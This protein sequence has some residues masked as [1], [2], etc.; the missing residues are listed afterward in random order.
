MFGRVVQRGDETLR[1][2]DAIVMTGDAELVAAIDDFD[3]ERAFD[4]AQILIE[5][6]AQSGKPL[7]VGGK[8]AELDSA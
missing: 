4:L 1:M 7:V 8:E 5:L 6:T 2:L 3:P